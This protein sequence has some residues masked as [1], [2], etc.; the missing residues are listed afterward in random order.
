MNRGTRARPRRLERAV[1]EARSQ[2]T[3]GLRRSVGSTRRRH[4]GIESLGVGEPKEPKSRRAE[5]PRQA[6]EPRRAEGPRSAAGPRSAKNTSRQCD[7]RR[8]GLASPCARTMPNRRI[9]RR[10]GPTFRLAEGRP[11]ACAG[12]AREHFF[13]ERSEGKPR[14]SDLSAQQ[15]SNRHVFAPPQPRRLAETSGPMRGGSDG[16]ALCRDAGGKRGLVRLSGIVPLRRSHAFDRPAFRVVF[17]LSRSR[18]AAATM[19]F[20][21]QRRGT[22]FAAR[23]G[24]QHPPKCRVDRSTRRRA[25]ST[26]P[27]FGHSAPHPRSAPRLGWAVALL[28]L[29]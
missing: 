3:E 2:G 27:P 13:A 12:S 14:G 21:A 26:P 4:E 7:I 10:E 16:M 9:R 5:R 19:I 15:R 17:A 29:G 22:S 24:R 23:A 8:A 25:R 18:P 28:G 1:E 6:E 11:R 20:R